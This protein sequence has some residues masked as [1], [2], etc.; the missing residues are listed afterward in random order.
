M[1]YITHPKENMSTL[2][3]CIIISYRQYW[4]LGEKA[5]IIMGEIV[6]GTSA[7]VCPHN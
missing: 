7:W 4:S 1:K 5:A 3:V 6:N 2:Y